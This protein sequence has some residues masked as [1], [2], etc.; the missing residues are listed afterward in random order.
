MNDSPPVATRS[1]SL[2]H[3]R[4]LAV[5]FALLGILLTAL[6]T[7]H[8]FQVLEPA[9]RADARS[10]SRILAQA[11]AKG[12]EQVL[13]TAHP[14]RMAQELG[15]ALDELLLL[16]DRAREL[17]FMR[18]IA[19]VMDYEQIAGVPRGSLDIAR[20]AG[21]CNDCFVSEIP[22]YHPQ[23]H[24]LVGIASFFASPECLETLV[25]DLRT[26][27]LWAVGS[28]LL[29]IALAWR[30]AQR[31]LERL[32]ESEDNLRNLFE[33]APFPMVLQK[34][35][36][37]GL[38]RA[39]Q[40][41]QDY[42]ALLPDARGLLT[43]EAWRAI[44]KA[45]LPEDP[46]E[47]LETLLPG[48][49]D[50][51]RWALVSTIPL[52]ISGRP[53]R[54]ISLVDVT[55]LKAIQKELYRTSLTDGLT[56]LYNRRHLFRK[57]TEEIERVVRFDHPFSIVLFDL[58]HFKAV[59]DTFGHRV[60]DEV[61]VGVAAALKAEIRDIDSVGRYGGEEFLMILP[62]ANAAQAL[63]VAQ[64]ICARVKALTWPQPGLEVTISGG[65]C[66]YAGMDIDAFV[67]AADRKLY[68]AKAG[69]RNRVIA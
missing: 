66:E 36:N 37:A 24:Q 35:G 4:N 6:I 21:R 69:G 17:P 58:D 63:H 3:E 33:A 39:N 53:S 27:L 59:N 28:M 11:Q 55:E 13:V 16:K 14:E 25:I 20:G 43:S 57:L 65:V 62:Y 9:L 46:A 2:R 50:G 51:D 38:S 67:D 12:I 23:S 56:G 61:L 48:E 34:Q 45:G 64:R 30:S 26:K 60:G 54:L 41:A 7:L 40:A 44:S 5:L 49:G 52:T 42:L 18:R 19:L 31:R 32:A 8:W 10:H 47:R 22:L 29:V 68:E 1:T 15:T